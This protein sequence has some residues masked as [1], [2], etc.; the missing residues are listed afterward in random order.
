MEQA[1]TEL[2]IEDYSIG[3]TSLEQVFLAFAKYQRP[4]DE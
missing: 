4:E 1:K 3:Q 2:S